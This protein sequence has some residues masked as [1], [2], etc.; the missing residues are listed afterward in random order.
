MLEHEIDGRPENS[1][2]SSTWIMIARLPEHVRSE[3]L[4]NYLAPTR[5]SMQVGSMQVAMYLGMLF[6]QRPQCALAV[7]LGHACTKHEDWALTRV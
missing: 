1:R 6:F 5:L 2:C 7:S 4:C 3:A